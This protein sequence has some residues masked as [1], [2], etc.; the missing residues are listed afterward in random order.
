MPSIT[1]ISVLKA[2]SAV[3]EF[4]QFKKTEP[5]TCGFLRMK[6]LTDMME[7]NSNIT[8]LESRV[9]IS[10]RYRTSTGSISDIEADSG[11]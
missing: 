3:E 1:S 6:G 5:D 9:R 2:D 4:T 8:L 7:K 10:V 11:K